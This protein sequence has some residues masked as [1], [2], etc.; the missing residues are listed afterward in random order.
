MAVS[1]GVQV[2][3]PEAD[4]PV[5]VALAVVDYLIQLDPKKLDAVGRKLR[6]RAETREVLQE[7]YGLSILELEA[8]LKAWVLET[9]PTRDR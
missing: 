2:R 5:A 7:V 9:Y 1:G 6:A 8:A 4:L 3:E